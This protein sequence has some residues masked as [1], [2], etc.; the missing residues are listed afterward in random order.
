[1]KNVCILLI[2]ITIIISIF[3]VRYISLKNDVSTVDKHNVFYEKYKDKN[4]K[5]ADIV[6]IVN[7]TIDNNECNRV[8][9]DKKGKYINNNKDSMKIDIKMI[10]NEKIY[11]METI[12][13]S[14]MDNFF[15]FYENI[16]FKLNKIEYH[17]QT[18]KVKYLLFE[19][20]TV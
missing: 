4:L 11:D 12:Y 16:E 13:F 15:K 19:Q 10:D 5:C 7:K 3:S 17:E 2:I 6:T 14:G 20:I 8:E 18:H 1:M 9:K